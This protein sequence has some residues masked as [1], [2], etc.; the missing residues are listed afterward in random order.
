MALGLFV[1][2][3]QQALSNAVVFQ[4][5]KVVDHHLAIQMVD[6]VLDTDCQKSVSR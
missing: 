6:L 1:L 5:R 2:F 4:S 3:L